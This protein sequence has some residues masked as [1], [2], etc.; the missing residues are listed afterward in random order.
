MSLRE[1]T[2]KTTNVGGSTGIIIPDWICK[3]DGINKKTN[4]RIIVEVAEDLNN[5]SNAP[6]TK[7]ALY[8]LAVSTH[9][10]GVC[11]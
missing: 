4:V 3:A 9:N 7:G 1:F 11:L 8:N 6:G 10:Q 2:K 5:Q